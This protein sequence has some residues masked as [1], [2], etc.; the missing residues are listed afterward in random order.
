ML[1]IYMGLK[2]EEWLNSSGSDN[3]GDDETSV[4]GS[5]TTQNDHGMNSDHSEETFSNNENVWN[6]IRFFANSKIFI[7]KLALLY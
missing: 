6:K 3:H 2:N 5:C 4:D 7:N 1:S